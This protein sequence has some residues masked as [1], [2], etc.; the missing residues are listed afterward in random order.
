MDAQQIADI[1]GESPDT[2]S[3]EITYRLMRNLVGENARKKLEEIKAEKEP[4]LMAM[5]LTDMA[6]E[7]ERPDRI[8]GLVAAR[9][10]TH[11]IAPRKSGKTTLLFNLARSLINGTA[12]LGRFPCEPEPGKIAWL[13]Y[14]MPINTFNRWVDDVG[15]DRER[16]MVVNCDQSP[17]WFASEHGRA[18][19]AKQL[20]GCTTLIVDSFARAYFGDTFKD[21]EVLAFLQDLTAWA[22]SIGINEIYT[23][24]HSGKDVSRGG[25]GSIALEDYPDQILYID[26]DDNRTTKTRKT[27]WTMGRMDHDIAKT[28]LEF[29]P[30]TRALTLGQTVGASNE[31]YR[32]EQILK[33]VVDLNA[34][35]KKANKTNIHNM[36]GGNKQDVLGLI[37]QLETAGVL[38]NTGTASRPGYV[39]VD[40]HTTP[41]LVPVPNSSE[42]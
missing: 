20:A 30:E 34:A 39:V 11:I 27:F 38:R 16:V 12:F 28:V 37:T 3:T 31:E 14:E 4:A 15:L 7:P 32:K 8:N 6:D 10:T 18:A 13:N 40:E 9:S 23:V 17:R 19:L 42:N 33:T 29:D 35:D 21:S 41:P 26:P 24:V 22:R 2:V 25:R 1:T 36:V 5:T